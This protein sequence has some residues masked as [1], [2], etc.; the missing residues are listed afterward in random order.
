LTCLMTTHN[1]S[2]TNSDTNIP[3]KSRQ[4]KGQQKPKHA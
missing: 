3:F 2:K 1:H 4:Q